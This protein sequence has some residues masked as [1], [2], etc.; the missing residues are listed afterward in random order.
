MKKTI[1]QMTTDEI[2][3]YLAERKSN[4]PSNQSEL[5]RIDESVAEQEKD[6]G[7]EDT[8]TAKDRV[9]EAEGEDTEANPAEEI[10]APGLKDEELVAKEQ[11]EN[12]GEPSSINSEPIPELSKSVPPAIGEAPEPTSVLQQEQ[13]PPVMDEQGGEM[14]VDY[15]Q[16]IDG[17]NAKILALEA[18][19]KQL[20]AKME[21][22]FGLSSKP[23]EFASVNSLYSNDTS[24]IPQMR[25][26]QNISESE[27]YEST[28]LTLA[29]GH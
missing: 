15:Q 14:P 23:G 17:Q 27:K 22:A 3:K 28:K 21:G 20:K 4:E 7:I 13:A 8:Q 9:D 6:T 26:Q 11:G 18:E 16:I 5:D 2:E 1:D 10:Q 25:K 19:N 24:D 12:S 29:F